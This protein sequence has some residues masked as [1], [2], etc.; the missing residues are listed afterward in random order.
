[1]KMRPF[2]Q[3][4]LSKIGHLQ[5]G[6]WPDIAEPFIEYLERPFC[7]PFKISRDGETAGLGTAILFG[8]SAWL[9]HIIVAR[10]YRRRGLGG[11]IVEELCRFC[12]DNRRETVFLI[13]TEEGLPVYRRAGFVEQT[14]YVFFERPGSSQRPGSAGVG[15]SGDIRKAEPADYPFICDL[16]RR[17]TGEDRR[18]LLEPFLGGAFVVR[19]KNKVSGFYLPDLREGPVAAE[20]EAPGL[21]LLEFRASR[22]GRAVLPAEN[23]RAAG[24]YRDRGYA[25]KQRAWRM[26]RGEPAPWQPEKIFNRIAG[27]VG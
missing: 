7:H 3:D 14:E 25:E 9:G 8:A 13:A 22:S 20:E 16:D 5:P 4:D 10:E 26:V 15:F 18:E 19:E 27:N 21:A 11:K 6:G 17:I 1:M 24:F 2:T 23:L 12:G